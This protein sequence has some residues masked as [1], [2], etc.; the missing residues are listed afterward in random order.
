MRAFL[1][2]VPKIAVVF[3]Q[4]KDHLRYTYPL[5][6]FRGTEAIGQEGD[7]EQQAAHGFKC[8]RRPLSTNSGSGLLHKGEVRACGSCMDARGLK[9][10]QFL[11]GAMHSNMAELAQWTVEAAKVL[12]F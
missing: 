12:T 8:R 5:V 7:D 1:V 3:Q 6:H 10:E 2:V 4:V 11:P 9:Q